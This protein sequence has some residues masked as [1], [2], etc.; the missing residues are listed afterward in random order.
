MPHSKLDEIRNR[1]NVNELKEKERKKLFNQLQKSG[2]QV[3]DLDQN[4]L[5][6]AGIKSNS[7]SINS[8]YAKTSNHNVRPSQ[9]ANPFRQD[10]ENSKHKDMGVASRSIAQNNQ[11]QQSYVSKVKMFFLR[12]NAFLSGIF[13]FN[14]QKFREGFKSLVLVQAEGSFLSIKKILLPLIQNSSEVE[15]FKKFLY[16]EDRLIDYEMV[17]RFYYLFDKNAFVE[18]SQALERSVDSAE[19]VI[20]RF[21]VPI[22]QL[23]QY[24]AQVKVST[25]VIVEKF[26]EYFPDLAKKY[27]VK[28]F[29]REFDIIWMKFYYM[30]EQLI[31]Y[32]WNRYNFLNHNHISLSQYLGITEYVEPGKFA[33]RWKNEVIEAMKKKETQQQQQPQDL[34]ENQQK[35]DFPDNNVSQGVFFIKTNIDF[36]KAYYQLKSKSDLR[37]TFD[38]NDKIFY[39]YVL[40]DYFDAEFNMLWTSN[41][42]NFYLT[43]EGNSFERTDVKKEINLLTSKMNQFY[44]LVNKYLKA[45]LVVKNILKDKHLQSRSLELK[46]K[47][48]GLE[49]MSYS[50]RQT[51]G[52][53]FDNLNQIFN[54]ILQS[55][56]SE[57]TMIGNWQ[58]KIVLTQK[59]QLERLINH[60]TIYD[61]FLL[62]FNFS[63]AIVWLLKFSE[64]SGMSR[65]L[66]EPQIFRELLEDQ[67][68]IQHSENQ[69]QN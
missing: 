63:S 3:V 16:T 14:A 1:L 31:D 55:K 40:I 21:F 13:N 44:E 42:I 8:G 20:K 48:K 25:M 10:I 37:S 51:M 58:E 68:M 30:L 45:C 19:D 66:S 33:R 32:Y 41:I 22:F 26:R 65:M 64:L 50:I 38:Y 15:E 23:F 49:Q 24:S 9:N 54:V 29:E 27:N 7:Q 2:G 18:V 47:E 69:I 5:Q 34:V 43:T 62:V 56:N 46:H 35:I 11:S 17:Y 57:E 36:R 6:N 28:Q 67:G 4:K 60:K 59:H 61:A 53:I 39:L 52:T 12:F